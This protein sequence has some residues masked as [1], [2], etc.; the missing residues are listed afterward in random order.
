MLPAVQ[1][2]LIE[3]CLFFHSKRFVL[4][5]RYSAVLQQLFLSTLRSQP[6]VKI[7]DR[8][9]QYGFVLVRLWLLQNITT[10]AGYHQVSMVMIQKH[11]NDRGSTTA[12][13]YVFVQCTFSATRSSL[14]VSNTISSK[15]RS[16]FSQ[17]YPDVC[18]SSR[19]SPCQRTCTQIVRGG[20]LRW[21]R[22]RPSCV[23]GAPRSLIGREIDS[24]R[25][26]GAAALTKLG[27]VKIAFSRHHARLYTVVGGRGHPWTS[28][29][30]GRCNGFVPSI[31]EVDSSTDKRKR[32]G[33]RIMESEERWQCQRR[34]SSNS[35][36]SGNPNVFRRR[37]LNPATPAFRGRSRRLPFRVEF[38]D[39]E[40]PT[41]S[42]GRREYDQYLGLYN[43]PRKRA[44]LSGLRENS[45]L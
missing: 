21:T 4:P 23:C 36:S 44:P 24:H 29:Q 17:T 41:R 7:Y 42:S 1:L 9:C 14:S 34:G 6:L 8:L 2:K 25:V 39:V 38:V 31:F 3:V 28:L 30:L 19:A 43:I 11:R 12:R 40:L 18:E 15:N 35:G 26:Y 10:C 22:L 45:T 27:V 32:F 16:Y 37:S 13:R 20:P 5:V 33:E